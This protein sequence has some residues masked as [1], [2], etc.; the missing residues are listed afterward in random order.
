MFQIY[1]EVDH[2]PVLKPKSDKKKAGKGVHVLDP[3]SKSYAP[4]PIYRNITDTDPSHPTTRQFPHI[5]SPLTSYVD[6]LYSRKAELHPNQR[7]RDENP[8]SDRYIE[9]TAKPAVYQFENV[10]RSKVAIT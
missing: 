2:R 10:Y 3:A 1:E 6:F 9:E 4:K 5:H 7:R 8:P